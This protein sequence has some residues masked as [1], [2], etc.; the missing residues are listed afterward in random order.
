MTEENVQAI[1]IHSRYLLEVA[2][3]RR[4]VLVTELQLRRAIERL[5]RMGDLQC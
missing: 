4:S 1:G 2:T 3:T 5:K